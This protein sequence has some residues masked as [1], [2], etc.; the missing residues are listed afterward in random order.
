M[1]SHGGCR[2]ETT[3]RRSGEGLDTQLAKERTKRFRCCGHGDPVSPADAA[4][5]S[6]EGK[7]SCGVGKGGEHQGKERR[8][9]CE[10]EEDCNGEGESEL[11][12]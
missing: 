12:T 9:T 6:S 4:T 8:G 7:R 1:G 11:G 3:D 5:E 2:H 10:M